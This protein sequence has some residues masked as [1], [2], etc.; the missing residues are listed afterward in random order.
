MVRDHLS[1]PGLST[2]DSLTSIQPWKFKLKYDTPIGAKLKFDIYFYESGLLTRTDSLVIPVGTPEILFRDDAENGMGNWSTSGSWG[3]SSTVYFSPTH[4]FT[5]SPFGNYSNNTN[6]WMKSAPLDLSSVSTATL[7]FR[8]QW[9]I[10][11]SWDFGVVEISINGGSSWSNLRGRYMQAGSGNGVQQTGWYGYD[12][13][14][15]DWVEESIDLSAYAGQTVQI[16]FRLMSDGWV[17]GDGWYVDD[18]LLQT[19]RNSA[20]ILPYIQQVSELDN[21]RFTGTPYPVRAKVRSGV[22]PDSLLLYYSNDEGTT[23]THITMSGNGNEYSAQIPAF[24]DGTTVRYFVKAFAGGGNVSSYPTDAPQHT[25]AFKILSSSPAIVVEPAQLDFT[26]PQFYWQQLPLKI[27]NPGDQTLTYQITDANVTTVRRPAPQPVE[28][29]NTDYLIQSV[30]RQ[31]RELFGK[32]KIAGSGEEPPPPLPEGAKSIV[33]SDST[34]DT[35]LPGDDILSVDF[36][37][38]FF[39]YQITMNFAGT[40]DTNS[41]GIIAFDVD[42][43]FGTGSYPPP[44][45]F[46]LGNFDVGAEY[47][48]VF[49]FANLIGDSLSLPPSVYVLD[50]S[51]TIPTP[52]SIPMPIQFSGSSASVNLLK[53]LNP[54]FDD[55]MNLGAMMLPLRAQTLPDVAPDYGHGLRGSE[56]GSSWV[57]ELDTSLQAAYPFAGSLA[58]GD[59]T[60]IFI[61]VAAAYPMGSYHAK[62]IIDNNSPSGT[63]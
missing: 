5:D 49:D 26:V 33:I 10:E 28:L 23:F 53:L 63:V 58:A 45:G 18:V 36:S 41:L 22:Q 12:G 56:L 60:E 50:M 13:S 62:L 39:N 2:F 35:N 51:D 7:T 57:T 20:Q 1:F 30:A 37:D 8:T 47:E 15:T 52:A 34:G 44:F 16:R 19:I 59:S 21:Q 46:G 9:D 17:T 31:L 27:S 3:R 14:R 40:P 61:K 29:S 43:N 4:S 48:V 32:E 6:V 42:Q 55:N 24:S 38:D 54:F 11:A 25:L